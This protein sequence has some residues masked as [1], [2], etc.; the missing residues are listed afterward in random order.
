MYKNLLSNFICHLSWLEKL[1]PTHTHPLKTIHEFLKSYKWGHTE[2]EWGGGYAVKQ[3]KNDSPQN[4]DLTTPK[5]FLEGVQNPRFEYKN[6]FYYYFIIIIVLYSQLYQKI[7][8]RCSLYKN[9]DGMIITLVPEEKSR[10]VVC[11]LNGTEMLSPKATTKKKHA[12]SHIIQKAV[13]NNLSE[14]NTEHLIC[15]RWNYSVKIF[16]AHPTPA[17]PTY[18]TLPHPTHP[19]LH[20]T[21]HPHPCMTH[22][23]LPL[24]HPTT[25]HPTPPLEQF[26]EE[27]GWIA[28]GPLLCLP[29]GRQLIFISQIICMLL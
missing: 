10:K 16:T 11:V 4:Q 2:V 5:S 26:W 24:P 25:P 27:M 9:L 6:N 28:W 1:S 17:W 12:F 15:D 23:T 21:P 7:I 13:D 3:P 8:T 29:F 14:E 20:Y 22:P 18:P 19:T